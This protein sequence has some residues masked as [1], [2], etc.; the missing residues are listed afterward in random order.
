MDTIISRVETA[1]VAICS[2]RILGLDFLKFMAVV[3]ITNSHFIPVY[4]DVNVNLA[5]LGVHGNALFFYVSG[6]LLVNG[7]RKKQER[8]DNWYKKRLQ[9][10]WPA[11]FLWAVMAAICWGDVL[12]W[13]K[14]LLAP[15]YW[16]L[17]A[18]AIYYF[19]FYWVDRLCL[20]RGG[21]F[22]VA[23]VFSILFAVVCALLMPH[24]SGSMFHTKW[25]Y[26]C[27]FSVM[28]MGAM[29]NLCQLRIRCNSLICDVVLWILSFVAYFAILAIGRNATD[30]RWYTQVIAL[31]PLHLFC[32][33][34]YKVCTYSWCTKLM[35]HKRWKWLFCWIASLTLEMYVVQFHVIT[36]EYNDLFPLNWL[37]V[38]GRIFIVAYVLRICVNV[39]IQFMGKEGW[40]WVKCL[41][42]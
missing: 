18:I 17:Q 3:M 11:V 40:H 24:T 14:I 21:Y 15:N 9:R 8:F 6:F 7:L 36:D 33:Y 25:H 20:N 2:N 28:I 1:M 26:V 12:T 31:A 37:I 38:F 29:T 13:Q 42:L 41:K 30:W 10:L 27:H 39:F 19:L 16:F 32:Y 35:T 34:G 4:K 23:F 5:T 22:L